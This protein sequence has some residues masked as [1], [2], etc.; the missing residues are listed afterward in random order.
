[1][2]AEMCCRGNADASHSARRAARSAPLDLDLGPVEGSVSSASSYPGGRSKTR[3]LTAASSSSCSSSS[4]EAAPG[5]FFLPNLPRIPPPRPCTR[6]PCCCCLNLAR[7]RSLL[8][9]PASIVDRDGSTARGEVFGRENEIAGKNQKPNLGKLSACAG[10]CQQSTTAIH[11]H[12]L[13]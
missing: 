13:I 2:Y 9:A 12:S 6:R 11:Q 7:A 10:K 3:P 5:S 8:L 4:S 1:M